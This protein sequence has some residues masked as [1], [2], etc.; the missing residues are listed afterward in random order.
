MLLRV[1]KGIRLELQESEIGV[2][3]V[4]KSYTTI[5]ILYD[6]IAIYLTGSSLFYI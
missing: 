1:S 4:D 6:Y 3:K 2:V 5:S